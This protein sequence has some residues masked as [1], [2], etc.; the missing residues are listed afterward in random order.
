MSD[1]LDGPN[2]S[3]GT[4][5]VFASPSDPPSLADEVISALS[6]QLRVVTTGPDLVRA[7]GALRPDLV[8]LAPWTRRCAA[9]LTELEAEVPRYLERVIVVIDEEPGSLVGR[10]L[11]KRG[12][13]A[14]LFRAD[15]AEPVIEA[16]RALLRQGRGELPTLPPLLT[17]SEPSDRTLR[18]GGLVGGR[19]VVKSLLGRG[20]SAEVYR[21]E[22]QELNQEI[23]LKLLRLDS[24]VPQVEDRFRQEL[25]ITRQ[26]AHPNIVRTFDFGTHQDRLYFTMELLDGPT[27]QDVFEARYGGPWP[28]VGLD[29]MADVARGLALA[30]SHG[31]V[32]RDVKP[33]NVFLVDGGS[34][35]ALGDFGIAKPA[36]K[37]MAQTLAG[38]VLGTLEYMA[39][40]RLITDLPATPA[41]DTYAVGVMLYVDWTGRLPFTA[42]NDGELV[43]AICNGT[44]RRPRE[45]NPAMPPAVESLILRL[46][47]RKARRRLADA[48]SLARQL[49][50]LADAHGGGPG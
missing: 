17:P 24:A 6:L 50:A 16:A 22:D 15:G 39:P 41:T 33:D 14:V 35:A 23:A 43:D 7:I 44:P 10:L 28:C 32:H 12:L 31:V 9:A 1:A 2:Q 4:L 38:T 18:I 36:S 5:L 13:A 3:E 46:L 27:M 49:D 42:D 40:E 25:A 21:V 37:A 34:R 47:Q 45:L 11:A 48:D 20:G 8:L 19:F 29:R 26:L 30:H